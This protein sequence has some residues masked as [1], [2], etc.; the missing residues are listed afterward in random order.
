[1]WLIVT[2]IF[3]VATYGAVLYFDSL[4]PALFFLG[5]AIMFLGIMWRK[6]N[7]R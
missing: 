5:A 3:A 6:T 2:I 7:R 1:M 4:A